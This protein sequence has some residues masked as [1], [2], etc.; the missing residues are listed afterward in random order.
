MSFTILNN[1]SIQ[2]LGNSSLFVSEKPTAP[3]S[4]VT[5]NMVTYFDAAD[6]TSY[7]GSG[8]TWNDISGQSRNGTLTNGV[9]FSGSAG[10]SR[11]AM[12]FDGTN[13]YVS[14]SYNLGSNPYSSNFTFSIWFRSPGNT[15]RK[16]MGIEG[17]ID[18]DA[19][20]PYDRH[21]YMGTDGKIRFSTY[22]ASS[23][24]QRNIASTGTTYGNNNWYN[25]TVTVGGGSIKLYVDGVHDA[26]LS[27]GAYA[28]YTNSY[29]KVGG[30]FN[31]YPE[32]SGTYW[33]GSIA[34]VMVHSSVLSDANIL[35][36]YNVLKG[37]YGK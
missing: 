4:L 9:T 11:S 23:G 32:S 13:D 15:G 35:N 36:N 30:I 7:N 18:V 33:T 37:R 2:I 5:T 20:K 3:P 21:F 31:G 25:A 1:T 28:G 8:T 22:D 10:G 16:M 6:V 14:T 26:T 12:V 17:A 27:G 29:L 34:V 24:G 19:S